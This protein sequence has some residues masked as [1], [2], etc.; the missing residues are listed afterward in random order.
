MYLKGILLSLVLLCLIAGGR[1]ET[2]CAFS[3]SSL[4]KSGEM[5]RVCYDVKR[6]SEP[7]KVSMIL[8]MKGVNHTIVDELVPVK[9]TFKCPEFQVPNVTTASPVYLTASAVANNYSY[10][11][12]T[13]VVVAPT[14]KVTQLQMERVIYKPG[15]TVHFTMIA[16]D[17][18][19]KPVE[20]EYPRIYIT[21]PK[22]NHLYQWVNQKTKKSVL[23]L[24]AEILLD[25]E[26][27]EYQIT[28][29]TA[30]GN[31][32][33]NSFSVELYVMPTFGCEL[34]VPK[35]ITI[36]TKNVTYKAECKYT[37]GQGVPAKVTGKMCRPPMNYYR[38]NACNRNPD[39]LCVAITGALDANGTFTGD[40]DT[41]AF[42]LD[43]SGNFMALTLTMTMTEEGSGIQVT[44]SRSIDITN[45]L[46]QVSFIR[47]NME[48]DYKKGID[49]FAEI[50]AVDGLQNP[51]S[52][53]TVELQVDGK[54]VKNLTTDADGK[55]QVYIDTSGFEKTTVTIEI[56]YKNSEECYD[57]NYIV[58]VYSSDQITLTRFYSWNGCFVHVQRP[59]EE[60][61]CGKTYNLTAKYIFTQSGLQK[62]E[63][64]TNF[65]FMIISKTKIL[66]HGQIRVDLTKSLQ[67]E[68]TIPVR[69]TP[70]HA[71]AID[72]VVY[73]MLK[74]EVMAHT[75]HLDT[76]KC[77]RNQIYLK[78]LEEKAT[79]GSKVNLNITASPR[80]LCGVRIYDS[81]LELLRQ[82]KPLTPEMV[83]SS[84]K[85]TSLSGYSPEGYY[86]APS[87]PPCIN[88]EKQIQRDGVW[89]TPVYLPNEVDAMQQLSN[90]G[91]LLITQTKLQKPKLCGAD[92]YFERPVF[93]GGISSPGRTITATIFAED[94]MVAESPIAERARRTTTVK[95]T[96]RSSFPDM[97]YF[98]QTH[99]SNNG[100]TLLTLTMPGTI[101]KWKGHSFCLDSKTGFGL[102]KYP[103]NITSFQEFFVSDNLPNSIIRGE[104]LIARVILSNYMKKCAKVRA[105]IAPSEDYTVQP[106]DK[107]DVSCVCPGQR[108]SFSFSI[109]ANSLGAVL[110][111]ITGETVHIGDTCQGPA[112]PNE[113]IYRDI[114]VKSINIKPEGIPKEV[115]NSTFV[116]VNDTSVVIPINIS[117][118]ENSV[119]DATKAKVSAIGDIVG[120]FLDKPESMII[121]PNGCGEQ[122]LGTTM[123][124]CFAV[125]YM[126]MTGRL[127]EERKAKAFEFM[128]TGYRKLMRFRNPDGSFSPFPGGTRSSWLTLHIVQA[129]LQIK[130]Y[131]PDLVDDG[132][133]QKAMIYLERLR[134]PNTG[135]YRPEGTMFNNGLQGV[136]ENE[137]SFTAMM[138]V[139]LLPTAYA[140]TPTLARDGMAFL[141]AASQRDQGLYNMVW[142]LNAFQ[143]AGNEKR[144]KYIFEKLKTMQIEQ[145]ETIHWQRP[146]T[147]KQP[148]SYIFGSPASSGVIEIVALILLALTTGPS[149]PLADLGYMSQIA[150]W[151]T[152]QQNS[153]G[154][155]R[156]T[157]DTM[158]ALQAMCSYGAMTYK[159]DASN[160]VRVQTG[161]QV[162]KEFKLD[163]QNRNRLQT[164]PLPYIPGNYSI[165]VSG[166]GCA[167]VQTTV[168]VFIPVKEE[169]SAFLID[170]FTPRE[171]CVNGVAYTMPVHINVSYNGLRNESNMALIKMML[172][173]G[174]RGEY[175]SMNELRTKVSKVEEENDAIIVYLD[176]TT[177]ETTSLTMTLQMG[178]RVQNHQPTYVHVYDYYENEENAIAVLHHPCSNQSSEGR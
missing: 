86:V 26:I 25:P 121:E 11:Q 154:A 149:P 21:D 65:N 17:N 124:L 82:D 108:A 117:P 127:T 87:D 74:Q 158:I 98:G 160:L 45:R 155:Y 64:T 89:Y 101:T 102:S 24:K 94:A 126:N 168:D 139:V 130:E 75:L 132:V 170:V 138:M 163:P 99:T 128:A 35:S 67:G 69:I 91:I 47:D 15:Q 30:S 83:F 153:R 18:N 10:T 52:N 141:D 90:V 60:L 104:T 166:K 147:P 55:A 46:G 178:T 92:P 109:K 84:L 1:S 159:K 20:E 48:Y 122:T 31:T 37:Y 97:L 14:G 66:N 33:S 38:G 6:H 112:D 7:V 2:Q 150:L 9:D 119:R 44:E 70:D 103:A 8:E 125:K 96:V 29:E 13:A 34:S 105:T 81:S 27:G 144:S 137:V 165:I 136:A 43:R 133:I 107:E 162:V 115:T 152:H 78:F 129:F 28:I 171:S 167:L 148:P 95:E 142:M 5:A 41:T 161:D 76:E 169:N 164:Q 157:K 59:K 174:Y 135:A 131:L 143:I 120:S 116:C 77:F 114:I 106:M 177:N 16:M 49:Y 62:G 68:F 72:V 80:S 51:L 172:P 146:N 134:N 140:S 156:N 175:K 39:G 151:I 118:P 3:V 176:K 111:N 123:P 54:P 40:V 61:Q 4:L 145:G 56:K 85:Y 50:M 58:P 110:V 79:P 100:S 88:A 173:S 57:S 113:P 73:S 42:Q 63:T 71:P 93:A 23:T 22:G 53:Q 36:L 32:V 12:R 19:L